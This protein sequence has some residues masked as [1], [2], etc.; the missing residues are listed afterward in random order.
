MIIITEKLAK[1]LIFPYFKI[2]LRRFTLFK[3][4]INVSIYSVVQKYKKNIYDPFLSDLHRRLNCRLL[5]SL[6]TI[7]LAYVLKLLS[8]LLQSF[9]DLRC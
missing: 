8:A 1:Y 2:S 3:R 7:F 6:R 9:V 5:A 4:K